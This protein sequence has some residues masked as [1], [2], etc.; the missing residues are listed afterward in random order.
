MCRKEAHSLSGL[1][2]EPASLPP[3]CLCVMGNQGA[4]VR[5]CF[6]TLF[7][8]PDGKMSWKVAPGPGLWRPTRARRAP[9]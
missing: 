6:V 4:A 9:R 8:S 5:E 2:V 7:C 3:E 1:L